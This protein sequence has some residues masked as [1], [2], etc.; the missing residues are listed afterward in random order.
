MIHEI[1]FRDPTDPR[2]NSKMLETNDPTEALISKIRMIIHTPKGAVL[3]EPNFGLDLE[4]WLFE[5]RFDEEGVRSDFY[6]QVARYIPESKNFRIELDM[7]ERTD[8]VKNMVLLEISIEG[9][10]YLGIQAMR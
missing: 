3:G 7:T 10:K 4:S 2:Y 5:D 6:A 1:Y 8:S 9:Q